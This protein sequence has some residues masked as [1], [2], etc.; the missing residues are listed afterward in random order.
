MAET[1]RTCEI[2]ES[3]FS[4]AWTDTHGVAQCTRCGAPYRIIH[5]GDDK[6]RVDKPPEL[7][8]DQEGAAKVRVCY[9]ATHSRLSAVGLGLSFPGGYDVATAG[10]IE[11]TNRWF[12]TYGEGGA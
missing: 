4:V 12:K 5:Y 6:K 9:E 11:A 7:T 8:L 3:P 10:D 1:E 2:C